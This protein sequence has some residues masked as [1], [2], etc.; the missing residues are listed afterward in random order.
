MKTLHYIPTE[1]EIYIFF[2]AQ[3]SDSVVVSSRTDSYRHN[4]KKRCNADK[5]E[6]NDSTLKDKLEEIYV[7]ALKTR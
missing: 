1:S 7:T 4:M 5:P 2:V 3:E 6:I